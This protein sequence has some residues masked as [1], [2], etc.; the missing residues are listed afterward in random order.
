MVRAGFL[1]MYAGAAGAK[2]FIGT[3]QSCMTQ[4][5]Q[6]TPAMK[7]AAECLRMLVYLIGLAIALINTVPL[8]GR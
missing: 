7:T 5:L 2:L 6:E 3:P 1:L 4:A 8:I